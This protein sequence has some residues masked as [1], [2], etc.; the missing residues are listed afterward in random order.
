MKKVSIGGQA[1][2]EGVMMKNLNQYAI[3]VRKPDHEIE[4]KIQQYE[5]CTSKSAFFRLPLI[6]GVVNFVEAMVVGVKTL[7]YS[8]SFYEDEEEKKAQEKKLNTAQKLWKEHGEDVLT[9]LTVLFSIVLAIGL[10][11]LLPA[12]LSNLLRTK[13][14]SNVVIAILEGI[15]RLIIFLLYIWGISQMKDIKRVF[16]YHGAEHK[17]INCFEAGVALTPENVQKYSRY[18]KRCGTS[19]LFWVMII[20]ILFFMLINVESTLLRMLYRLL[21]VPVIAGVSYEF[22][23]LSGKNESKIMDIMSQPGLWIQRLTTK[24][25]DMEMLEVAI[26]S[27]EG[28]LDWKEYQ[29]EMKQG[30]IEEK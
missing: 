15:L 4:V 10:F 23:R 13:I 11:I 29:S 26:A 9:G 16:M 6:R 17:T 27:V 28:V 30:N 1:V 2:I 14:E 24:E 3:A 18:H 12:L 5:S 20:S 8:A 22:I 25:P 7:T 19:F 21:L